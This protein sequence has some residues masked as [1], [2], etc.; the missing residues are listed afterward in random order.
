MQRVRVVVLS[1]RQSRVD[2]SLG[3]RHST[4]DPNVTALESVA[5]VGQRPADQF[6]IPA[7]YR[8]SEDAPGPKDASALGDGWAIHGKVL[9]H[10]SGDHAVER[11]VVKGQCRYVTDRPRSGDLSRRRPINEERVERSHCLLDFYVGVVERDDMR[12][13][14]PRFQGMPAATTPD[15]EYPLAAPQAQPPEVDG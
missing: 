13:A 15:I 3:E 2:K 14:Q 6:R 4:V 9:E 12:A 10:L 8:Q 5:L 1:R 7:R 11:R